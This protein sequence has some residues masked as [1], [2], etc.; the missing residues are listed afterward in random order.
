[1]ADEEINR[2]ALEK[3]YV[4]REDFVVNLTAMPIESRGMVNTIRVSTI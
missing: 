3:G 1:M 4:E 2:L